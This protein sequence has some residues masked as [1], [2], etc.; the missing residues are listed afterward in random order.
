M[1]LLRLINMLY[2]AFFTNSRDNPLHAAWASYIK[3][4]DHY[5]C[6]KCNLHVNN[7]KNLEAHHLFSFAKY[8]LLRYFTWNGISV[9][10][11]CHKKLDQQHMETD[12]KI[13]QI[14]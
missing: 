13:I 1:G 10:K 8:P 3:N 12:N 6:R 11:P 2:K 9:C 4:R 7:S 5:K 14:N